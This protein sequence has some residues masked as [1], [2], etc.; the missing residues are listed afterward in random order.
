MADFNTTYTKFI[1]PNEGYLGLLPGDKGGLTYGGIAY[2][3]NQG[4]PGWP[5]VDSF[6]A[7]KGGIEKIKNNTRIP[8]VDSMVTQFYKDWWNRL[9]LDSITSQNVANILFDWIVN[10]G[11]TNP[12]K[13][14]QKIVGASIDGNLGPAT[15]EQINKMN[16]VV[17][18]NAI[19]AAREAFYFSIA[20]GANANFLQGWLNR[21]NR[22][23][24]LT[25]ATKIGLGLFIV[26]GVV[27]A[28]LLA[29]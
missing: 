8:Q 10:S 27:S 24:T 20:T 21:L 2:N 6:I 3:F 11:Q 19:K 1:Q 15:I 25:K 18:N 14:V 9:H 23:P 5:I 16:E 12:I 7:S 28:I 17:L 29:K 13:A 4:W 26:V 22:F